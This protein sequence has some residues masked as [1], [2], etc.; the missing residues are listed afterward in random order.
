MTV[1]TLFTKRHTIVGLSGYN[2][3]FYIKI[4]FFLLIIKIIKNFI[5]QDIECTKY[6][7]RET[8]PKYKYFKDL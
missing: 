8:S 6:Y 4:F 3:Y 2:L 5:L 1:V 7:K